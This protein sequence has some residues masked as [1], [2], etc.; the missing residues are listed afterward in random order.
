VKMP[1]RDAVENDQARFLVSFHDERGLSRNV[2]PWM[3]HL[4]S[5]DAR[6]LDGLH[7]EFLPLR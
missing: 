5:L 3:P 6:M 1:P 7:V 4:G 2:A